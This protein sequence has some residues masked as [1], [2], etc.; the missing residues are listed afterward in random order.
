MDFLTHIREAM[1]NLLAGKLRSFLAILGV[2]VGTG[3]VV[4]LISS[5]QLAT[6]H[7]LSQFKT[8]GTNLLSMS[9]ES[10]GYDGG[11]S[12]KAGAQKI[13]VSLKDMP[14]IKAASKQIVLVAPYTTLYQQMRIQ[15]IK[16]NGE[17]LGT[18][19]A[20]AQIV[21]IHVD[22]G[23]FVS[24]LDNYN[25]FAVIGSKLA[26]KIRAKGINPIGHQIQ[27]GK[28]LFTIIG[29]V[30]PWKP[31]LFLFADIDNG[32]IVPLNASYLVGQG[33]KINNIMFRL[34]KNPDIDKVKAAL[35]K[36]M[37]QLYPTL[38]VQF[39]DPQQI[40]SIVSKQRK[41]FTW[42]LG[43]I[44]GI[45]LLVGG[46]GVMNIMLV[47]VIERRQEIGIRMAIGAHGR[48][49]LSMFLIES[50]I[51]T[52]FGGIMGIII[53]LL[54]S[55]IIAESSGWGFVIDYLAPVLG[56]VVSVLVGIVSGFYPAWRASRLDPIQTLTGE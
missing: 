24:Y 11:Q 53:G 14:K 37:A 45:S 10:G 25:P 47:S 31:N 43:A 5:S 55:F 13:Q 32:A 41:T 33:V 16:S 40:I 19:D 35:K 2:L 23:R 42:L 39:R 21:K 50:V 44:G 30:K 3:S 27:I 52:V 22:K 51:L 1:L 56:F 36:K 18:D 7:A 6:Q 38:Q 17:V 26:A 28:D 46:I 12:K 29:T 54:A 8:L 20:L 15:D 49:I 9:I 48:D 4:A 34:V